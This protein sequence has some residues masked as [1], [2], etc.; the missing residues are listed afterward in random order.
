M[1]FQYKIYDRYITT[2][3]DKKE[4]EAD[5][6]ALGQDGWEVIATVT[7]IGMILKKP[8]TSLEPE[9]DDWEGEDWDYDI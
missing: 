7:S 8:V 6:N 9:N 2:Y 4:L 5:L 3:T 1:K